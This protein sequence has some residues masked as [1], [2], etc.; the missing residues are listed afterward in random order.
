[1][2]EGLARID[3]G[4]ATNRE[5]MG[6]RKDG[7]GGALDVH[8]TELWS[9]DGEPAGFISLASD[10]TERRAAQAL[11]DRLW[12]AI[13]QSSEAVV[14]T[15]AEACIEYVNPAFERITGYARDEVLGQNPRILKS[16]THPEAFYD[17]MW[18]ALRAGRIWAADIVNR[19]KDGSVFEEEATISPIRDA[20]G[21]VSGYVAVK[22]D[23]TGERRLEA[24]T[25]VRAR[26]RSH[27]GDDQ[28]LRERCLAGGH[29]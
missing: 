29:G 11:F 1:M 13:E 4:L 22:R 14:I 17:S 6:R 5:G 16:G 10:A 9:D 2:L 27:H 15:D 21:S 18:S 20:S 19:R 23:V 12:A 26:A 24:E 8:T 25:L 28:R 7:L 3:A